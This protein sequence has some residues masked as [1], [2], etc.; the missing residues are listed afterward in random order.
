MGAQ[1][2]AFEVFT[3][4]LN[5]LCEA[6]HSLKH[7]GA[8]HWVERFS[9]ELVANEGIGLACRIAH[10]RGR[11]DVPD[12]GLHVLVKKNDADASS[13]LCPKCSDNRSRSNFE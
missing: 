8:D 3:R 11:T 10:A 12:E 9:E 5:E 13:E 2:L 1:L 4:D 7:V 6:R